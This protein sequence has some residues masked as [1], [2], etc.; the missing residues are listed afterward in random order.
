M[1]IHLLQWL[2]HG[3]SVEELIVSTFR[4]PAYPEGVRILNEQ[5]YFSLDGRFRFPLAVLL[6]IVA[7]LSV[8]PTHVRFFP[9]L[10]G[11]DKI[12]SRENPEL[13]EHFPTLASRHIPLF[14]QKRRRGHPRS[15]LTF[16]LLAAVVNDELVHPLPP[17][18]GSLRFPAPPDGPQTIRLIRLPKEISGSAREC[19]AERREAVGGC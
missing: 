15:T 9:A 17:L 18:R 13:N 4:C 1:L 2:D 16:F 8:P 11:E 19:A 12:R 6:T 7:I 10:G 5:L 3:H 14:P